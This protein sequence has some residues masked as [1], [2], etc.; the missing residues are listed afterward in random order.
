MSSAMRNLPGTPTTGGPRWGA[1]SGTVPGGIRLDR[2]AFT[3]LDNAIRAMEGIPERW[4]QGMD[5][6]V[7][8]LAMAHKGRAQEMSRGPY[9]PRE[10]GVGAA[11][12][13]PVRRISQAYYQGWRTRKLGMG[14]WEVFNAAREAFFIEH[15]INPRATH[16]VAPRRVMKSSAL[17]VIRLV[18]RTKVGERF[19]EEVLGP[20]KDNSGKFRT[21]ENR[22]RGMKLRV[23]GI[24]VIGPSGRL[25][26]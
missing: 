8:M 19:T 11:G 9:D 6:L 18:A 16:H 15:G 1:R 2:A 7:Q 14:R 22:L 24:N 4:Q 23:H 5:T 13:I 10:A 21:T 26:G 25:P 17:D 12:T 3:Q 20:L